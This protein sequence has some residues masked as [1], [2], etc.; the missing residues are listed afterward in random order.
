MKPSKFEHHTVFRRST[1]LPRE[2]VDWLSTTFGPARTKW[3]S[4][5][6][7]CNIGIV[8]FMSARDKFLFDMRW[9]AE[10]CILPTSGQGPAPGL[11][12]LLSEFGAQSNKQRPNTK[13][14]GSLS[15]EGA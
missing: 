2:I 8:E 3:N 9:S 13:T 10:V 15:Y 1:A 7:L 5:M 12:K 4:E 11:M 14:T 6:A